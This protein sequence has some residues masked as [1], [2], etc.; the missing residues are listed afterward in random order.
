MSAENERISLDRVDPGLRG[1]WGERTPTRTMTLAA[2]CETPAHAE[3]ALKALKHAAPRHGVRTLLVEWDDDPKK[4]PRIDAEIA[5]HE[6]LRGPCAESVRL[7]ATGDARTFVPESVA[8]LL[9]PDLP[10]IVW[11]VGDLPD[12]EVLLDRVAIIARATVAAVDANVMD[13]RDLAVLQRLSQTV[14]HVALADFCWHRLRTWQEL[15]A[16]FFD[17]PEPLADLRALKSLKVR[18]QRR[19]REPEP[20]SNQAALYIGWLMGRF[21]LT[22]AHWWAPGKARLSGPTAELQLEV[23]PDQVEGVVDGS[24]LSIEL[25]AGPGCYSVKRQVE[26]PFVICWEGERPGTPFPNQCVRSH[27]LDDGTLLERVLLR[28]VRDPLY[29]ASL[30]AAATLVAEIA[31]KARA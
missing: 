26:N 22:H 14:G 7:F 2:L 15:L 23:S 24:L 3:L 29:E 20:L 27:I 30:A 11:W 8:R 10:T 19:V 21:G 31:P 25:H 17:L 12:H 18:F 28:P 1:L 13:L 6:G 9:A 16:R 4:T 5:L